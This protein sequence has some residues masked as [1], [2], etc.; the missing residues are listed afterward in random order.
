[1]E[2]KSH[3]LAE[4]KRAKRKASA[5]EHQGYENLVIYASKKFWL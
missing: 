3:V 1:M 4:L 2:K 5:A